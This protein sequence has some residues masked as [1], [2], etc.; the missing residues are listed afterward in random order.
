MIQISEEFLANVLGTS[1]GE[2]TDALK[3][4]EELK[5]AAEVESFLKTKFD[6]AL[7]RA[8]KSGHKEG[9]GRGQ[10]ESLTIKER[11]L[12]DR[13][14]VDGT[15]IDEVID[16]IIET[17]KTNSKINPDDVKNSEVFLSETKRLKQII[18]EKEEELAKTATTYAKK[19]TLRAA[20]EHGVRLLKEKNFVL[21]DD[22]EIATNMLDVLFSK[23]E[24]EDTRLSID[25]NK[26]VVLDANGRPKENEQGTK[27]ITFDDHLTGIAKKFFKQAV[28]DTRKSPANKNAGDEKG[29]APSSGDLPEIKSRDDLF[30]VMNELRGDPEKM[31]AVKAHYDKMVEEGTIKE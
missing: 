31:K 19:E 9:L 2:I 13:F 16:N 29:G 30:K 22:D 27:D 15:T 7:Y 14:G 23:L 8:K 11:E 6:E 26:I 25:G 20:K 1:P 10:K 17:V 28:A 5:P 12:K 24:D 4:G 21:P 3:D 18:A